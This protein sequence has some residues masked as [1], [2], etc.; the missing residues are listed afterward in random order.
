M[1]QAELER[2]E[3][4]NDFLIRDSQHHGINAYAY[5]RCLNLGDLRIWRARHRPVFGKHEAT[6]LDIILPYFRNALRNIYALNNA[7][8][9]V[10]FWQKMLEDSSVALFLFDE[11]GKLDFMNTNARK[12]EQ[13]LSDEGYHS[14]KKRILALSR[15]DLSETEWGSYFLSINKIVSP[16]NSKQMTSVMVTRSVSEEVDRD[17]LRRRYRLSPRET[18]ICLLVCKGLTDREIASALGIAFSTVR[19]YMKRVF[20]K[21]NATNRSELISCLLE[22]IVDFSF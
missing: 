10:D 5:D 16:M 18:D 11:K 7:H 15:N 20:L 19:T 22:G 12:I 3:F 8:R 2:T 17:L 6:L 4:F 1:P 9:T 21:L 14:L 13:E